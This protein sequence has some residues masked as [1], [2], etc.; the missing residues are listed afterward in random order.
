MTTSELVAKLCSNKPNSVPSCKR[1]GLKRKMHLF[2]KNK[3]TKVLIALF[4]LA[5]IGSIAHAE[6]T[7]AVYKAFK[8]TILVTKTALPH[9]SGSDDATKKAFRKAAL[10]KVNHT[11][12][13]GL[14]TWSF[15]YTVFMNRKTASKPIK[16]RLL[17]GQNLCCQ[18]TH[19]R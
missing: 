3:I 18:Q 19:R 2:W 14:V 4:A 7:L 16:L 13:D 8:G 5:T 11:K 6:M 15:H 1:N 10:K 12:V 9:N 17:L